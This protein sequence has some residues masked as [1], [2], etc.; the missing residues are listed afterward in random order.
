MATFSFGCC[1]TLEWLH[2]SMTIR[3]NPSM[4]ILNG[5]HLQHHH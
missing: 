4:M 2:W 5:D 1:L 3:I